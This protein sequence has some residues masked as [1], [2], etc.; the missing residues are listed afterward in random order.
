MQPLRTREP[1]VQ[2]Q[3]RNAVEP[4]SE[5]VRPASVHRFE[6]VAA[7]TER[8]ASLDLLR[9]VPTTLSRPRIGK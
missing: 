6:D 4:G 7:V 9:P 8:I 2:A 3:D 5:R 1:L